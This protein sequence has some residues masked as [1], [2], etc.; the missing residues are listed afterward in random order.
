MVN[1]F[2]TIY[3]AFCF[4]FFP[5]LFLNLVFHADSVFSDDIFNLLNAFV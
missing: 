5:R 1:A 2:L 3:R 4:L